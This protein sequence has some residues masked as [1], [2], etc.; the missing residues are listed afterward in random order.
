MR[1]II[2]DGGLDT[3]REFYRHFGHVE[4]APVSVLYED[5]AL[6][7]ADDT[8]VLDRLLALPPEK[9]QPVLFFAAARLHG[10]P[11]KSWADARP[12]IITHWED[13]ATTMR[14]RRTQTN[15]PGR[16][17]VLNLAFSRIEGPVA[18]I[19]VGAS[20]GLCLYPDCWAI[21]YGTAQGPV[22]LEP[23]GPVR[24]EVE[25]DCGLEGLEPPSSLP[26]V[27]WRAGIDLNPLDLRREDD[28][29]WLET[30]VWP[31]ME[32]RLDRIHA[33]AQL[34]AAQPPSLLRGD[35]SGSLPQV[36]AQVPAGVTPVVFHSAVL[37]YLPL[38]DR[39]AFVRQV[40]A[41][42]ARWVSNEGAGILPEI[43][44]K[45]PDG[46]GDGDRTAFVLALDGEPI[47]RTGPHGQY[48][49]AL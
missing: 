19:E 48:A 26:E 41:A 28:R 31:G 6:G 27:V 11:L 35:L 22:T 43:T 23:T 37:A 32:Y 40:R 18:L 39:E 34:V 21:R 33:G 13:I 36:L 24:G 8:E 16:S 14:Q 3:L 17:A 25:I 12:Q 29:E 15:E 45:L 42:G 1:A 38:E 2:D 4:A 5:W 7:V 49:R 10:T 30:L 47:A 9:R 20:A 46:D 44:A